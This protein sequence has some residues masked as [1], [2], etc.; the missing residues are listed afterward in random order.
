[1]AEGRGEQG[2]VSADLERDE[3]RKL[4]TR[5]P[6]TKDERMGLYREWLGSPESS[7]TSQG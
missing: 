3:V 2:L 6:V 1:M 5:V 4:R 7:D